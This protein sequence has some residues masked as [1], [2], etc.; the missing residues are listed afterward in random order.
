M[1]P[2]CL[3]AARTGRLDSSSAAAAAMKSRFMGCFLLPE[4]MFDGVGLLVAAL[5]AFL[6]EIPPLRARSPAMAG[7]VSATGYGGQ[8]AA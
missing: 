3:G 1:A 4:C 6:A 2:P 5:G 8:S 7:I